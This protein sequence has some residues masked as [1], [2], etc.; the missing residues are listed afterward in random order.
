M[1]VNGVPCELSELIANVSKAIEA[2]SSAQISETV[3]VN[4]LNAEPFTFVDSAILTNVDRVLHNKEE[5]PL[6][7]Q[8][9][10]NP[11]SIRGRCYSAAN[12]LY[13]TW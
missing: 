4:V 12:T 8:L 7:G 13:S 1:L 2:I 11:S 10:V 9:K 6:H 5:Y 3:G